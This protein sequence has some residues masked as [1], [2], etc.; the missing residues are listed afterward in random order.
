M[1]NVGSKIG[2]SKRDVLIVPGIGILG[3][4]SQQRRTFRRV[5]AT[6]GAER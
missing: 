1:V 5:A 2:I 4:A 6:V 3:M